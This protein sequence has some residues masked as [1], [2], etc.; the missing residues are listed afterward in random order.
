MLFTDILYFCS[1]LLVKGCQVSA[2]P[3]SLASVIG[4][5]GLKDIDLSEDGSELA[6]RLLR[7]LTGDWIC[8][9]LLDNV[10]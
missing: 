2:P 1:L 8:V 10:H 3:G 6:A 7:L 9:F 5:L 4:S